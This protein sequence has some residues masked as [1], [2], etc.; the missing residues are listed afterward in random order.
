MR[1]CSTVQ[2]D[3]D[4]Q[5]PFDRLAASITPRT[6][7][8]AIANPNSPSGTVATRE[9]IVEL[10]R[11]APQAVVLVDE[12]YFHFC[13]E[14]VMDLSGHDS[15]PHRCAHIFEGLWAGGSCAWVCWPARLS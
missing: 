4:L 3:D 9:Q 1:A 12:A 10:A 2:A 15:E 11:R 14:T 5:F 6:K 7:I 8:I 13:G